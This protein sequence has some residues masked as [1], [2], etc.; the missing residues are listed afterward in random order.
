MLSHIYLP[1]VAD[2][3]LKK[4]KKEGKSL[5]V[6]LLVARAVHS[7]LSVIGQGFL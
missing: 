5:S 6:Y 3:K 4:K 2:V 1:G 7:L